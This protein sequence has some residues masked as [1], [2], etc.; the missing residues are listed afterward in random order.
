M[1]IR[2]KLV[3]FKDEFV[4]MRQKEFYASSYSVDFAD[5]ETGKIMSDWISTNTNGTLTPM[6]EIDP[7]QILSIISTVYFYD[8]WIDRFDSNNTKEDV[9]YLS[10]GDEVKSTL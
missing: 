3:I 6:V 1:N 5:I 10:N 7:E 9:F 8:Q 2:A 4:K